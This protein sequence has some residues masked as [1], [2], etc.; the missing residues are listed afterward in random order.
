MLLLMHILNLL[1]LLHSITVVPV[2]M[3]VPCLG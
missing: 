2:K 1:L 3:E